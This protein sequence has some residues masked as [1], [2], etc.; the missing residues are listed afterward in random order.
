[1]KERGVAVAQLHKRLE[2]WTCTRT[3]KWVKELA[4]DPQYVAICISRPRSEK[5]EQAE[6]ATRSHS[7]LGYVSPV[8]FEQMQLA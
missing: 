3:C 7:T 5:P 8:Q 4:A 1:V 2:I 6:I